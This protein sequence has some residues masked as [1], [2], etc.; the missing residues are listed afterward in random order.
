MATEDDEIE[1]SVSEPRSAETDMGSAEQHPLRDQVEA[2]RY[3][4]QSRVRT[5][6]WQSLSLKKVKNPG[7]V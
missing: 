4:K 6:P 3:L 1:K 2:A 5:D 7:A